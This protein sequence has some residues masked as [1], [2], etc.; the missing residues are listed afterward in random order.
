MRFII[1]ERINKDNIT[2]DNCKVPKK[3]LQKSFTLLISMKDADN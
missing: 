1:Y 3:N 2:T